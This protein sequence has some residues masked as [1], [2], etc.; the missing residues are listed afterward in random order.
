M[1]EIMAHLEGT[2]GEELC[3]REEYIEFYGYEKA[4]SVDMQKALETA[5]EYGSTKI[6]IDIEIRPSTPKAKVVE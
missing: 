6:E 5:V 4:L 3:Y 1:K 2:K